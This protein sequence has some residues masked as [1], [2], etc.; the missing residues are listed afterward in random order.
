[1]TTD[2]KII[3]RQTNNRDLHEISIIM[4]VGTCP[5]CKIALSIKNIDDK[6]DLKYCSSCRREFYSVVDDQQNKNKLEYD[7]LE[8]VSSSSEGNDP[9]L[10]C[11]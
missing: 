1:M 8:T 4:N 6:Y 2:E 11:D 3:K 10:I 7:D 9:V 5:I